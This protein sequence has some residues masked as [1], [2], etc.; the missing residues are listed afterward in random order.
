M[1]TV[2]EEHSTTQA[3]QVSA[4]RRARHHP[5]RPSTLSSSIPTTTNRSSISRFTTAAALLP[6]HP[7]RQ[8]RH[9]NHSFNKCSSISE[10]LNGARTT[11]PSPPTTNLRGAPLLL[12][13]ITTNLNPLLITHS[14]IHTSPKPTCRP[15]RPRYRK[16]P[17]SS[18]RIIHHAKRCRA[19]PRRITTLWPRVAAEGAPP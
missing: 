5:R 16:A 14:S 4:A 1:L 8:C 9:N 19:S 13:L 18:T 12:S 10:L 3:I 2:W 17:A 6:P 7:S 15:R 11:V